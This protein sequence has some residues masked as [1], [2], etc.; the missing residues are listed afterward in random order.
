MYCK[1]LRKNVLAPNIKEMDI[2]A[3]RI[4]K[5]ARPGQFVIVMPDERG[6]R[7]PLTLVDWSPTEGWIRLVFLEIGVSTYKLGLKE[8]GEQFYYI[9]GPLGNPTH[10]NK[11]GS[12]MVIGGGVGVP[13]A[14][15]IARA[16]KE[17][18]NYVISII[19]ARTSNLLVYE[20]RIRAV[21]DEVYVATDDG[22]KGFKGFT[23]DILVNILENRVKPDLIWMVGPAPM[24]KTCSS[25]ARKYGIKAIA[26][27]NP[28]MVCGMGMCGACRVTVDGKTRFTC[29][30]GPEFEADKVDW[31]ELIKRLAMYRMEEQ[32]ALARFKSSLTPW[33]AEKMR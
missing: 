12:V 17:A 3:P 5:I 13:A 29:F 23:S 33:I 20:D 21:S 14:Y 11:F 18:G 7:I 8:F 9:A 19:G 26:S 27:L 25:I 30:E 22:S 16:F 6:E 15:P 28:I 2:Y 4:A 1:A 31:D 10:I 32:E 24:M